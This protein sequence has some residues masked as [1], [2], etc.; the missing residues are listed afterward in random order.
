MNS[1][2][3]QLTSDLLTAEANM[4]E[5]K[6]INYTNIN[7]SSTASHGTVHGVVQWHAAVHGTVHG[8]VQC[9]PLYRRL[10]KRRCRLQEQGYN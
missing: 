3:G 8:V 6:V 5:A 9:M 4:A 7:Y 2:V 10:L 1:E